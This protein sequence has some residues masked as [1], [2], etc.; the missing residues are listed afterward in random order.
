MC[1]GLWGQ[2]GR[3]GRARRKKAAAAVSVDEVARAVR[4][5]DAGES[6]IKVLKRVDKAVEK[7]VLDLT[8]YPAAN[9]LLERLVSVAM[10]VLCVAVCV[11]CS[12][13]GG[14]GFGGAAAL[15]CSAPPLPCS[16]LLC[17]GSVL[18]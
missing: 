7:G 1:S 10:L 4:E 15:L 8:A 12:A 17:C 6:V 11:L 3:G 16:A 5:I 14:D 18:H 9:A 13:A 2:S